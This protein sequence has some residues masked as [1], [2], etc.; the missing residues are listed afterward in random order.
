MPYQHLITGG[1]RS[2]INQDKPDTYIKVSLGAMHHL[3]SVVKND[4]NP[5]WPIEQW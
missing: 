5:E 4:C 1:F 2:L 3:T